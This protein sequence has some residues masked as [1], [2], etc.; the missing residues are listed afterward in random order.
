MFHPG[1]RGKA[2]DR[3][4]IALKQEVTWWCVLACAKIHSTTVLLFSLAL[5]LG[6]C[7]HVYVHMN[8]HLRNMTF[9]ACVNFG[10]I[11]HA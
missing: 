7:W 2:C 10:T 3:W 5:S 9:R 1:M 4:N 11:F 6:V 8:M